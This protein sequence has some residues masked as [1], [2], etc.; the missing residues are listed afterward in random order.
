MRL[1]AET[2]FPP[3]RRDETWR[4]SD[5]RIMNIPSQIRMIIKHVVCVECWLSTATDKSFD[6]AKK[7]F[8]CWSRFS[9]FLCRLFSFPLLSFFVCLSGPGKGKMGWKIYGRTNDW[10]IYWRENIETDV[11]WVDEA[12]RSSGTEWMANYSLSL[13]SLRLT[14][15][16]SWM[17]FTT[18]VS[19]TVNTS[20]FL[21]YLIKGCLMGFRS[22]NNNKSHLVR[23]NWVSRNY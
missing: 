15:V 17:P 7:L 10:Q 19:R 5:W 6:E 11:E 12:R 9:S 4:Q 20:F 2:H 21:F 3:R 18:H 1:G 13:F 8:C 14:V 23:L 16:A 22:Q